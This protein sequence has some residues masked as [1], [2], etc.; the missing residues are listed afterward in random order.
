MTDTEDKWA[1][2]KIERPRLWERR[3]QTLDGLD[4]AIEQMRKWREEEGILMDERAEMAREMIG[5]R[6]Q[7]IEIGED[8]SVTVTIAPLN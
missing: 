1:R 2:L 8:G 6:A 7:D 5:D 3:Q 4:E